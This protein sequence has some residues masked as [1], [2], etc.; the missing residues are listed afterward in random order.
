MAGVSIVAVGT[1]EDVAKV[2]KSW[3]GKFLAETLKRHK[4]RKAATAKPKPA[5]KKPT[6]KKK[7]PAKRKKANA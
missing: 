7:A 4:A 1:P 3:T 6:A 5:T 2:K